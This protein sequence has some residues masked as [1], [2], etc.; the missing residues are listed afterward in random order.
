VAGLRLAEALGVSETLD[1]ADIV[2]AVE[3]PP[4]GSSVVPADVG[5]AAAVL[6]IRPDRVAVYRASDRCSPTLDLGRSA[7]VWPWWSGAPLREVATSSDLRFAVTRWRADRRVL[8]AAT[9][10][11]V[12]QEAVRLTADH[13]R[14]RHQFGRPLGSFQALQH[15]LA[16]RATAA[17]GAELLV[18]R[19]ASYP[20]EHPA[21]RYF[22]GVALAAA[23]DAA[24]AAASEGMQM[25]GGYGYSLEYD[26][27]LYLRFAVA[28]RL[29]TRDSRFELDQQPRGG[30]LT[31]PGARS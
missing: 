17:R 11:G 30:W 2:C 13:L 10:V 7:L 5:G 20:D 1:P 21:R 8:A 26:M 28:R 9:F 14:Y 15:R 16:D 19:A 6:V 24:V 3:D 22:S 12:A 4:G 31:H 23:G 27:H 25:F 18:L 29:L